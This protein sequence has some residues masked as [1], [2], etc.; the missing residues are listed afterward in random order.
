[1]RPALTPTKRTSRPTRFT[2]D[3]TPLC[4]VSVVEQT[5]ESETSQYAEVMSTRN[6]ADRQVQSGPAHRPAPVPPPP[7][8]A[9][10]THQPATD[11][12]SLAALQAS[13]D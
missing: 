4:C 8:Y 6:A 2:V 5:D 3:L 10:I 12:Q 9:Q 1:M 11:S 13:D 7:I